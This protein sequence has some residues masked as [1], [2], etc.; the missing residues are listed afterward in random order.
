MGSSTNE[1]EGGTSDRRLRPNL[2]LAA[3]VLGWCGFAFQGSLVAPV[4]PQF[5]RAFDQPPDITV[6]V[7]TSA[8]LMAAVATPALAR[9]GDRFGKKRMMVVA[10]GML[11]VGGLIAATT[12]SFGVLLVGR[13]LQG[14]SAAVLPLGISLIRDL[15]PAD[16]VHQAG[17]IL[18]TSI[19]L[20]AGLGLLVA[21]LLVPASGRLDR[22]LWFSAVYGVVA[23][24]AV[25]LFVPESSW[26]VST[27]V[28]LLG[29]SLLGVGLIALLLPLSQ[30]GTWGWTSSRTI[31]LLAG[32]VALMFLWVVVELRVRDPLVDMRL[33]T[34]A[35]VLSTSTAS[36]AFG[37]AQI[38]NFVGLV[39]LVQVQ[40][41]S[42]GYGFSATVL[43]AGWYALPMSAALFL[44][45]FIVGPLPARIPSRRVIA[46]GLLIGA[47]GLGLIAAA[48]AA[49]WEI[50]VFSLVSGAGL[51]LAFAAIPPQL[52]DTVPHA[53][54]TSAGAINA[55]IFNIGQVLG[56]A[57]LGSVLAA[58]VESGAGVASDHGYR[59]AYMIGAGTVIAATAVFLFLTRAARRPELAPSHGTH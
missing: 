9:L 4:L 45:A 20:A 17:A 44:A 6:Y 33:L 47:L 14:A 57:V 51:G 54:V 7:L 1:L 22:D 36:F 2:V 19:G 49:S 55:I 8:L 38:I 34:R 59:V 25:M 52:L 12:D 15:F 43:H 46:G 31:W 13:T 32:S 39:T 37:F 53:E 40:R 42:A 27:G 5:S 11:A 26:R 21:G 29:T 18:G 41:R 56:G 24:A 58:S 10:T 30:G 48:H 3:I 16:R 28:D 23:F 35:T 50:Y